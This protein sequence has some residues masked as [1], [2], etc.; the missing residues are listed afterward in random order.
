[1][2]PVLSFLVSQEGAYIAEWLSGIGTLLAVVFALLLGRGDHK[3]ATAELENARRALEHEEIRQVAGVRWELDRAH[4][5]GDSGAT[6]VAFFKVVNGSN[7]A[8]RDLTIQVDPD[9]PW[10]REL[11]QMVPDLGDKENPTNSFRPVNF[12]VV[13]PGQALEVEFITDLPDPILRAQ[14]LF[15]NWDEAPIEMRAIVTFTDP[16]GLRWK[17]D[18]A[19]RLV[20]MGETAPAQPEG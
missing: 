2:Q 1:M 3:R 11:K 8:V 17:L 4:A 16:T 10:F 7:W 13:H 9:W 6:G 15:L 5:L 20:R 12:R 18:G 19:H 14:S